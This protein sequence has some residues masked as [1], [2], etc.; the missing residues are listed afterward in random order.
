VILAKA[1]EGKMMMNALL[2]GMTRL[3]M[4]AGLPPKLNAV[5][6]PG[7]QRFN[8]AQALRGDWLALG[9]DLHRALHKYEIVSHEVR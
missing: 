2:R 4:P 3:V 6:V 5:R 8:D 7:P 1:I 9:T